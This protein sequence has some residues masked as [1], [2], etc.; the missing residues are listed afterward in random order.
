MANLAN[1]DLFNELFDFRRDFDQMFNRFFNW[2]LPQEED[3]QSFPRL[4]AQPVAIETWRR[5][6]SGFAARREHLP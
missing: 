1:R 4:L 5:A 6:P 3:V 2:R